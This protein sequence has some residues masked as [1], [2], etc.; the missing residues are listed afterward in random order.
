MS[1]HLIATIYHHYSIIAAS[2]KFSVDHVTL[3]VDKTPDETMTKSISVI[4]SSLG[5]VMTVEKIA[6]DLYNIIAIASQAVQVI[7]NIPEKDEIYVDITSGR[8]PKSLGLLFAAYARS[9]RVNKVCYV[10]EDSKQ[11]IKL[12]LMPFSVNQTQLEVLQ[13]IQQTEN[14][15]TQQIAEELGVSKGLVYRYIKEMLDSDAV[16]KDG[17]ILSLSD[18]GRILVL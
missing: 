10:T 12:P 14:I 11:I 3:L 7:D 4:D 15:T 1:K 6:V 9:K 17:E 2:N 13:H 8:K 18:F 5:S 16:E